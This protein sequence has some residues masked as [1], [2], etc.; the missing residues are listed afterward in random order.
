[1]KSPELALLDVSLGYPGYPP[2]LQGLNLGIDGPGICS[3][4]GRNGIGKTT[5]LRSVV[6]LIP[7]R[8]GEILI[9]GRAAGEWTAEER[10]REVSILFN[11]SYVDRQIRVSEFVLLGRTP[12]RNRWDR[13]AKDEIEKLDYYLDL[14]G[15]C[16]FKG[17]SCIELSDGQFQKVLL[18]RTLI[19]ECPL[20]LL[21]EP[22]AHLDPYQ[23]GRFFETLSKLTIKQGT[24]FLVSTHEV[25]LAW[26]YSDVWWVLDGKDNR[27]FRVDA[28]VP[29][30]DLGTLYG[31]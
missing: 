12:H 19:Q 8:Q 16:A 11:R 24:R 7:P 3:L 31:D 5:L 27:Q 20:V 18:A 9:N 15:L 2:I 21:D 1:M 28:S 30:P 29:Y 26:A 23:K 6:Q 14:L 25:G 22:T 17:R 10:A 4:I 13:P